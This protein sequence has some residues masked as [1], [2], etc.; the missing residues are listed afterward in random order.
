MAAAPSHGNSAVQEVQPLLGLL[1]DKVEDPVE[2]RPGPLAAVVAAVATTTGVAGVVVMAV[3]VLAGLHL[4]LSRA[5][6]RVA[7]EGAMEEVGMA[8]KVGTADTE[9][10]TILDTANRLLVVPR[11]GRRVIMV[12]RLRPRH[13][14]ET[15][16]RLP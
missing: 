15:H 5:T 6:N 12:E 7:T 13:R 11:P 4:G 2:L 1:V 16:L 3:V 9:A 14:P 8:S 10:T